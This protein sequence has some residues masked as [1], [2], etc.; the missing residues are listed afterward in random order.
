MTLT[1]EIRDRRVAVAEDVLLQLD[2][3]D[4]P[5]RVGGEPGYICGEP[6]YI[7]GVDHTGSAAYEGL[8]L[9]GNL[10]D[11]VDIV[12]RN[13]TVCAMGALLLSKAR[14]LDEVPMA[15]L[16]YKHREV[17]DRIIFIGRADTVRLLKDTFDADTLTRA[18]AFFEGSCMHMRDADYY[19]GGM[20]AYASSMS[21]SRERLVMLADN[22][23]R[24]RGEFIV[25]A[26]YLKD[27]EGEYSD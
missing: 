24:N 3:T 15:D 14:L 13:C 20:A 8:N 1:Q 19:L 26:K 9:D 25:P 12:Q 11:Q 22:I 10:K 23:A 18:E 21:S 27:V 7:S 17:E 5:L 6:G 2:R 16:A 4:V